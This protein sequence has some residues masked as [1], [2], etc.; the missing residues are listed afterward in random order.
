MCA[1][2]LACA[3][4]CS[5]NTPPLNPSF[6]PDFWDDWGSLKAH[7]S[8]AETFEPFFAAADTATFPTYPDLDMLPIGN[9]IHNQHLS[10][11]LF[12]PQEQRLLMTLWSFAGAPLIMG[13]DLPPS[14]NATLPLLTNARLLAVHGGA[15][16]RAVLRS[17]SG[18]EAHAWGAAPGDAPADA[19]LALINAADFAQ[20]L[21]LPLASLPWL[22]QPQGGSVCAVELWEGAPAGAF[23][24]GSGAL[25]YAE[26]GPHAAGAFRL[27]A[28]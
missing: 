11:S 24:T 23:A 8:V 19:Y 18:A 1:R 26:V 6:A 12:L 4:Y 5:P 28:C 3:R 13:G 7:I 17:V 9:V 20:N 10:P 21:T 16:G 25:F 15:R 14:S 22:R 2:A 27:T